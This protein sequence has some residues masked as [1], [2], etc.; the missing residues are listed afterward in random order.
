MP[1]DIY[2]YANFVPKPLEK[3]LEKFES[4]LNASF[5]TE[6]KVWSWKHAA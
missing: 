3:N 4:T 5:N 1:T 6:V 2:V